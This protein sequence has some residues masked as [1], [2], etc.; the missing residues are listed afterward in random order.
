MSVG[1]IC[2]Y[3]NCGKSRGRSFILWARAYQ[4]TA[5]RATDVGRPSTCGASDGLAGHRFGRHRSGTARAGT[6]SS[7]NWLV[8]T[9]TPLF[10]TIHTPYYDRSNPVTRTLIGELRF[11]QPT[12]PAES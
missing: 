2:D 12:H 9:T 3:S 10:F 6:L 4:P 1:V 5:K 8:P 11:S 7:S